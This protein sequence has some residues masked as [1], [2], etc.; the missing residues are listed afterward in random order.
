MLKHELCF[1]VTEDWRFVRIK[2]KFVR[3]KGNSLKFLEKG[4]KEKHVSF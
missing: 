3:I 1:L 2:G 4:K